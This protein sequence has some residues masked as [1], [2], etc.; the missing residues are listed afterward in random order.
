M[1]AGNT[2]IADRIVNG[3]MAKVV[4]IGDSTTPAPQFWYRWR[5]KKI[6][7]WWCAGPADSGPPGTSTA[8]YYNRGDVTWL[9]MGKGAKV[10]FNGAA[11][12][13]D[14]Y[15]MANKVFRWDT[16]PTRA[17]WGG[18]D[19]GY[20][21]LIGQTSYGDIMRRAFDSALAMK[22]RVVVMKTAAGMTDAQLYVQ[23]GLSAVGPELG[24]AAA[25]AAR[26]SAYSAADSYVAHEYAIPAAQVTDPTAKFSIAL[27]L[28]QGYVTQNGK[29]VRVVGA[30]WDTG[31]VGF[32]YG[33]V[34]TFGGESTPNYVDVTQFTPEALGSLGDPAAF[35]FTDALIILGVNSAG[36]RNADTVDGTGTSFR[37]QLRLLIS[38]LRSKNPSMGIILS[39]PHESFFSGAPSAYTTSFRDCMYEEAISDGN[40]CFLN[41]TDIAGKWAPNNIGYGQRA[42]DGVFGSWHNLTHQYA[43]GDWVTNPVD[44]G[45]YVARQDHINVAPIGNAATWTPS[46][47]SNFTS[48]QHNITEK[49]VMCKDIVHFTK[50][51]DACRG[52]AHWE[53]LALGAQY[54]TAYS[55]AKTQVYANSHATPKTLIVQQSSS[56]MQGG[57]QRTAYIGVDQDFQQ[58]KLQVVRAGYAPK[59]AGDLVTILS[60]DEVREL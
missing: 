42:S 50:A 25:N 43:A 45:P 23:A 29:E 15:L 36:W 8:N 7:S 24:A 59:Q 3:G 11:V 46:G 18:F 21:N 56:G 37:T 51:G 30:G 14:D 26:F 48:A 41:W 40:S 58:R 35:G 16:F 20:E 12:G 52:A 60:S 53:A 34:V 6:V 19:V 33:N 57:G 49:N 47:A 22:A 4:A 31:E 38:R 27:K 17:S 32:G 28:P 39:S 2:D 5:P 9:S 44:S 1:F 54:P 13:N 10:T 55:Y